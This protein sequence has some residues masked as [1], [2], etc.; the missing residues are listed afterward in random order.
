[1]MLMRNLS[2]FS[3]FLAAFV[4]VV[5]A[6]ST[7]D[8]K[9]LAAGQTLEELLADRTLGDPDAPVAIYE[10]ASLACPA[11]AGFHAEVLPKLK[12][13]YIDTGK[14]KLI[15][16]DY[17]TGGDGG[18]RATIAAML[19][20]CAPPEQYFGFLNVLFRTQASWFSAP[21]PVAALAQIGQL[22]GIDA[23]TFEACMNDEA[24]FNGIRDAQ[25]RYGKEFDVE[26]TPTLIFN[27]DEERMVSNRGWEALDAIMTGLVE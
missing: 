22:G 24:L 21:D 16:R 18:A 4:L 1:M 13:K 15:Y 7:F 12:E 17:P 6:V 26:S 14:A 8:S 5:G 25:I 10:Y 20:R 3:T 11:C 9:A 19:A 27:D 2:L 23:Q